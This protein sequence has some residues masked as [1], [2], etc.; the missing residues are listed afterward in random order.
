MN[1]Y[2]FIIAIAASIGIAIVIMGGVVYL[3][4][5]EALND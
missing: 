5:R 1:D 4:I 2:G 3:N